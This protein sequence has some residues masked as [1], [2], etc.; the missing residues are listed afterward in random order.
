MEDNISCGN[1]NHNFMVSTDNLSGLSF[2]VCS[3]CGAT[4][5]IKLEDDKKISSYDLDLYNS[6]FRSLS[7][8]VINLLRE[9]ENKKNC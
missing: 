5:I 4:H 6:K 3:K 8:T 9:V 7:K 2:I 1:T